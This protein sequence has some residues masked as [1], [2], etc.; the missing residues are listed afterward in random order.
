MVFRSKEPFFPFFHGFPTVVPFQ[1]HRFSGFPGL[2][3]AGEERRAGSA[4]GRLA[5]ASLGPGLA[6]VGSRTNEIMVNIVITW[7]FIPLHGE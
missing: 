6:E 4:A 5:G 2:H 1:K 7:W 3:R